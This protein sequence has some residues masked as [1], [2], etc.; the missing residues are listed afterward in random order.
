MN[1]ADLVEF[2]YDDVGKSLGH[3]KAA[4]QRQIESVFACM[5]RAIAE[6]GSLRISGFGTFQ[7]RE[8]KER[9]GRDPRS[10]DPITIPRARTVS[11]RA[12]PELKEQV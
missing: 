6:D 9:I 2:V 7:A 1:K 12:S 11:F 5:Q 4:T 3:S 8:R 10:G